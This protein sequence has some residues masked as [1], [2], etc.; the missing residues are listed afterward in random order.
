MLLST[1]FSR[2]ALILYSATAVTAAPSGSLINPKADSNAKALMAYLMKLHASK[3]VLSGQQDP[4]STAWVTANIGKTPAITGFDLMD[5]SPSR[6]AYG[7][8]STA[9]EDAISWGNK[10]GIVT[11]CW[12]WV[13][14]SNFNHVIFY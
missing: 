8:S 4:T 3:Q 13:F 2:G 14:S 12:H 11:F 9:I 6:V 5:Y 10:G 7:S 1:L